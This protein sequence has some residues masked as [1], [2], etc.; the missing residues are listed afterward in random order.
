MLVGEVGA[1]LHAE[2]VPA[3]RRTEKR[4]L[5][6]CWPLRKGA[7]QRSQAPQ[8]GGGPLLA[9]MGQQVAA[10]APAHRGIARDRPYALERPVPEPAGNAQVWS[11]GGEIYRQF[12][13]SIGVLRV[14]VLGV[15]QREE[16]PEGLA[17][18]ELAETSRG[19]RRGQLSRVP[20]DLRK[21]GPRHPAGASHAPERGEQTT[22]DHR[23]RVARST[24]PVWRRA[25]AGSWRATQ[26]A[27]APSRPARPASW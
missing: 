9:E 25:S 23:S 6:G 1:L 2:K 16:G 14:G 18:S 7:S 11:S 26:R 21:C 24:K 12:R 8:R 13:A 10:S 4:V 15:R 20:R 22:Q 27:G 5:G 3:P 19:G 17:R